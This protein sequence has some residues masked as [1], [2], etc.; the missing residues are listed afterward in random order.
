MGGLCVVVKGL[1]FYKKLYDPPP[2]SGNLLFRIGDWDPP[3]FVIPG[4]LSTHFKHIQTAQKNVDP[5]LG[6]KGEEQ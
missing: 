2:C 5:S 1:A 6:S 3:G 4:P